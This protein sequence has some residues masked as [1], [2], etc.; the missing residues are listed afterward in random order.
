MAGCFTSET[1]APTPG[2]S[3]LQIEQSSDDG[4]SWSVVATVPKP[5]GHVAGLGEPHVVELASRKL[6]AMVRNEPKDRTQCFLMQSE[7]VDG[8][9]TWSTL[10][11]SGIWGYPPQLIQL[12]N[13]WVVVSYGYRREPYGERAC[14]SRDEGKTWDVQN[15][16]VLNDTGISADLGYPSSTQLAD[17]SILTV[18]YQAE[19]IGEP[20]CLMS[21][22]WRFK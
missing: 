9:K 10:H 6:I 13:G 5:E 12:K 18:Y 4:R 3:A 11:S 17:G 8:G 16:I 2:L 1:V 19:K 15:E 7:S 14:I 22:H 21:T 20:T